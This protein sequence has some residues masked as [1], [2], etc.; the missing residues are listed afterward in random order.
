[1]SYTEKTTQSWFARVKSALAGL[2]IGPL[3]VIVAIILLF[4]NEGRAIETYKALVEGAG[5]VI[6][7][8]AETPD[9]A[10]EGKLVHVAGEV[11]PGGVAEDPDFS[12][13]ADGAFGINRSVDM[14]QWVE[15]QESKT[16]KMLGGGE[17]TVTTY[18]YE[19]EWR[20]ERVKSENFRQ[21]DGHE[22][23]D[24][25]LES[26]NFTVPEARL[27]GFTLPGRAVADLGQ[28]RALQLSDDDA[29]RFADYFGTDMPVERRNGELY[30]GS[31]PSR[32]EIGDLRISYQR[33]DLK[34]ASFVGA[35]QGDTLSPYKT[36]SGHE[37]FLKAAGRVPAEAMFEQAQDENTI[38]TWLIRAGGLVC[39]LIGF[40]LFFSII[41]VIADVV[42]LFGSIVG[43]GT[44]LVSLILTLLLGPVAIAIG[45]FAYRPLLA[46]AIVGIGVLVAGGLWYMRRGRQ[47][48]AVAGAAGS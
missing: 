10:N 11:V 43:F 9:S 21:P 12:I 2:V 31:N 33:A 30:A 13:A 42:P 32:P 8:A 29:R 36:T 41:G 25:P 45:W 35:Q 26:R 14:Y 23:P 20:S 37:I 5:L 40:N 46:L 16:E 24:L 15:K 27:G 47:D 3:L 4:W 28:A 48:G 19:K 1:M 7:V 34:E 18:T 17:E 38:I 6:N 22:N 44:G 39:M